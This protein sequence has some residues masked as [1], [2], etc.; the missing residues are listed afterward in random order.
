MKTSIDFRSMRELQKKL[1][2]LS[3]K[4]QRRVLAKGM[5]D[6]VKPVVPEAQRRIVDNDAV[7]T[8][9]LRRSMT[10]VVRVYSEGRRYLGL[11]G[12]S[13]DYY[14]GS[15]GNKGKRVTRRRG[16]TRGDYR[17]RN[18]GKKKPSNYAHLVEF[19]FVHAEG[20]AP[21]KHFWQGTKGTR[22]RRG[23][24]P[25]R[26]RIGPRP[27]L[28]PAFNSQV[29]SIEATLARSVETAADNEFS[30]LKNLG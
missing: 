27:F 10:R 11:V 24:F 30:K 15:G 5:D 22:H 12:P 25:V 4:S 16:E 2:K 19:G 9:A 13:I 21:G 1:R 17:K 28:A 14:E 18:A 20:F 6:A 7:D 23:T 26:N 3:L 29:P 8:G